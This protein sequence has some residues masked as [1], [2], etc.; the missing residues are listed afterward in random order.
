LTPK[1]HRQRARANAL[2]V[3]RSYESIREKELG[4]Q[5]DEPQDDVRTILD[6]RRASQTFAL[7]TSAP[8]DV[9]EE[10]TATTDSATTKS[11]HQ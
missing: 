11:L 10:R 9:V 1:Q 5:I 8:S 2:A 7:A 4:G 6:H 3:E